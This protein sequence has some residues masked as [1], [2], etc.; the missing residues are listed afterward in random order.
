V[1]EDLQKT[2]HQIA[3]DLQMLRRLLES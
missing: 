1:I 3:E 2:D